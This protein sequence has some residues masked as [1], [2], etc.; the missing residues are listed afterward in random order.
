MEDRRFLRFFSLS[1]CIGLVLHNSD[2]PHH[3][4]NPISLYGD[5]EA[6]GS[7]NQ[8][9]PTS[10]AKTLTQYDANNGGEFSVPRYCAETIFPKLDY[11]ADPPVQTVIVKD[12]HDEVWKFRHIY[13]GRPRRHLLTAGSHSSGGG[14]EGCVLPYGRFCEFLIDEDNKMRNEG[15]GLSPNGNMRGKGRV[16]SESVIEAETM[17]A[18]D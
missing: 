4:L 17:A 6:Y 14:S 16:R 10:F 11:S 9:K 1:L 12:V 18:N 5:T 3:P 7:E 2:I 13:R 15:E 8:E